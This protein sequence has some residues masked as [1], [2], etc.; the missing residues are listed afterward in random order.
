MKIYRTK[1]VV[2]LA[3]A[4]MGLGLF[5]ACGGDDGVT[6]GGGAGGA[7]PA[8]VKW[9]SA[10][11]QG[12]APLAPY[13]I[14][15]G[16]GYLDEIEEEFG[17]KFELSDV[18]PS[19][20][21]QMLDSDVV[22]VLTTAAATY[23]GA[24]AKGFDFVTL[25]ETHER[26]NIALVAAKKHEDSL[27][28]DLTAFAELTWGYPAPGSSPEAVARR[29]ADDADIDWDEVKTVAYGQLAA[30]ASA[31][32]SGRLDLIATDV[33]TA[34]TLVASDAG[35][36]VY[37]SNE[38]IEMVGGGPV[39]KAEFTEK[40]PELTQAI[41]DAYLKAMSTLHQAQDDP[42]KILALFP[43]E[44]QDVLR[45]GF[46]EAW[47]ITAPGQRTDG[48]FDEAHVAETV[49]FLIDYLSIDSSKRELLM[50]SWSN[51]YVDASTVKVQP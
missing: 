13:L 37:N 8:V 4:V 28:K 1:A 50:D 25:V 47:E 17:T 51:V 30:G 9:G 24:R 21:V 46:A 10:G 33:G 44:Y 32:E 31:L 34:G 41:V 35:Y 7:A 11:R 16:Q 14:A 40:Y 26:P 38:G 27:G 48:R 36:V 22:D 3:L 49:D 39:V 23:A 42:D 18:D 5:A 12:T 29:A 45:D 43:A 15:L 19:A 6:E 2:S 20:A